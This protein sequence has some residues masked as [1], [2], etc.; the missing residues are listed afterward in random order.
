[1]AEE[2]ERRRIQNKL[3]ARARATLTFATV[4]ASASLLILALV[5]KDPA[6]IPEWIKHIGF[7][8][9]ISGWLYREVTIFTIDRIDY[10][11]IGERD[12]YPWWATF[13]RMVIVRF[14][15]FLP[16]AAWWTLFTSSACAGTTIIF[17]FI[18]SVLVPI[19]ELLSR[20]R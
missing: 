16:T 4:A 11:D 19:V 10:R 13:P 5:W 7:M 3:R 2:Q 17:T 6:Q 18:I 15:L 20:H 1:M 14:F 8:F 12:T 9:S